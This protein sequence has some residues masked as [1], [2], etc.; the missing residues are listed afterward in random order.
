MPFAEEQCLLIFF[1]G[2][3][4]IPHPLDRIPQ[5]QH[6]RMRCL[7]GMQIVAHGVPKLFLAGMMSTESSA[8][9]LELIS[10]TALGRPDC[11]A[12]GP[13]RARMA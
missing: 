13:D 5:L 2:V 1:R 12:P 6:E 3:M 8:F 7:A 4:N 10:W 9:G 11:A